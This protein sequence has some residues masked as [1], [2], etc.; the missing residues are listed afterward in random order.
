MFNR[1]VVRDDRLK[2]RNGRV[3]VFKGNGKRPW[4]GVEYGLILVQLQVRNEAGVTN[5]SFECG[6]QGNDVRR[7]I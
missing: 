3:T 7:W 5:I 1:W 6:F 4:V 2:L